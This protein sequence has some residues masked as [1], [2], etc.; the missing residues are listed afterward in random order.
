MNI[1]LLGWDRDNDLDLVEVYDPIAQTWEQFPQ[2][3]LERAHCV[4]VVVSLPCQQPAEPTN[5]R[6]PVLD[7]P[8][9]WRDEELLI[10]TKGPE[11]HSSRLQAAASVL[12]SASRLR[13][14]AQAAGDKGLSRAYSADGTSAAGVNAAPS[15][16]YSPPQQPTPTPEATPD[17]S[18]QYATG[19]WVQPPE[20]YSRLQTYP[21]LKQAASDAKRAMTRSP[22]FSFSKFDAPAT[23]EPRRTSLSG[24]SIPGGASP[25][26]QLDRKPSKLLF[27]NNRG[28]DK[29]LSALKVTDSDTYSVIS[30]HSSLMLVSPTH[31]TSTTFTSHGPDTSAPASPLEEA[32]PQP[33]KRASLLFGSSRSPQ[34]SEASQQRSRKMSEISQVSQASWVSGS[35]GLTEDEKESLREMLNKA[36]DP[37]KAPSQSV[38]SFA[39]PPHP[40][41]KPKELPKPVYPP[42]PSFAPPDPEPK[43]QEYEY[44]KWD[45]GWDEQGPSAAKKAWDTLKSKV[46]RDPDQFDG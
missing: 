18:T 5:S 9:Q 37:P 20:P 41:W 8:D 43:L 12:M 39:P 7:A 31:S 21:N 1:S 15:V 25:V 46:L 32:S 22:E 6:T 10:L 27:R 17:L 3:M 30:E 29:L 26:L 19:E 4:S 24:Q 42:V 44:P 45:E 36:K 28:A 35:S 14:A 34:M 40:E 33:D 13:D 16:H 23:P 2:M 11:V 38:P